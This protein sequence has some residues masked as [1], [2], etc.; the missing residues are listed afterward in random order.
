M[1]TLKKELSQLEYQPAVIK[2]EYIDHKTER[3]DVKPLRKRKGKWL[4]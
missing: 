1:K 2:E 4:K 3:V